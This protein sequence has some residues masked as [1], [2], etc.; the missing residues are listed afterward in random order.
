MQAC[1]YEAYG[2]PEVVRLGE[3]DTP[4]I[5]ADEV[6]VRVRASS[7]TTADYRFRASAFPGIFWLPGR[8][9]TGLFRPRNPVL[10]RD[11]SGIVQAVGKKVTRF[12]V[13]DPVFGS[14]SVMGRGAHAEYVAVRE[15]GAIL[16][17]PACL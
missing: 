13:G 7:V 15:S 14:A 5:E 4:H 17:K 3:V 9:M 10:G 1:I 6:L 8:L 16:H 2:S 12:R 11:C